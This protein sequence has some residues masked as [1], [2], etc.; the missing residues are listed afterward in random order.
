MIK[1]SILAVVLLVIVLGV[2]VIVVDQYNANQQN[3]N[4]QKQAQESTEKM[5]ANRVTQLE[6]DKKTLLAR[7]E[8]VRVDCE[9]QV[10]ASFNQIPATF[11]SRLTQPSCGP[12]VLQ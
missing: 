12:A 8:S 2:S 5:L 10:N 3:K 6:A 4:K 9:R 11:K 1:K 7:Y